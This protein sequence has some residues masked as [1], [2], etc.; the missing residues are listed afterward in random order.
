MRIFNL[1]CLILLLGHWNGCLQWLVPMLQEF[2]SNSWPAIEELEVS[3]GR[4]GVNY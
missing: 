4:T 3:I 1:V 2:P